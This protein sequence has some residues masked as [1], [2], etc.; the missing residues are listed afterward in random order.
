MTEDLVFMLDAMG[1]K[2]GIDLDK[3]LKVRE[4]VRTALPDEEM[5][6]FTPDAGLPKNY[7]AGRLGHRLITFSR[8]TLAQLRWPVLRWPVLRWLNRSG[9]TARN[10]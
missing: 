7:Q 2:T 8:L 6:G 1:L 4:V 10:D 3:L 5:Y 9:R